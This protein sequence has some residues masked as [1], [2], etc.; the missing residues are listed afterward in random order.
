MKSKISIVV[1]IYNAERYIRRCVNSIINQTYTSWELLLVDDGSQ[2]CSGSICDDIA[3][4]DYRI[5]VIHQKNQGASMA[6]NVGIVN[7]SCEWIAFVDA[8]DY[9]ELNWLEIVFGYIQDGTNY[10]LLM[11]G[12]SVED[13]NGQF[14]RNI[15]FESCLFCDNYEYILSK[16]YKHYPWLFLFKK[17][18]IDIYECTFPIGIR[19]SEDQCFLLK[20]ILHTESIKVI[21]FELYH[22]NINPGSI[23]SKQITLPDSVNNLQ[24][25]LLFAKYAAKYNKNATPFVKTAVKRLVKDYLYY[26]LQTKGV[27]VQYMAK[28]YHKYYNEIKYIEP[29]VIHDRLLSC[30]YY[31]FEMTY[32][33][34]KSKLYVAQK[35]KNVLCFSKK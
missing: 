9:L 28:A 31:S 20:Y 13:E 10:D 30:A 15:H 19:Q 27:S 21:E 35:I 4:S 12:A 17:S 18:I 25:G 29:E 23:C 6:R 5:K 22:Y 32:Y 26:V 14:L 7:A 3:R 11:W 34:L 1:P 8:D 2:D 24:V 16:C 33:F